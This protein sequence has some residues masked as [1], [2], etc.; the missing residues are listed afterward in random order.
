MSAEETTAQA[1][2]FAEEAEIMSRRAY[3]QARAAETQGF[4]CLADDY[5]LFAS[6]AA[7]YALQ[8]YWEYPFRQ[9]GPPR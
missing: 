2:G 1:C 5:Y 3:N 8:V 6:A 7:E 9:E 4:L